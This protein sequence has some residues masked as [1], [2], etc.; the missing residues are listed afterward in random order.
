MGDGD[1]TGSISKQGDDMLRHYLYEAAG[2]LLTTVTAPSAR[3]KLGLEASQVAGSQARA[4]GS[5]T[6]IGGF[7]FRALE[8]GGPFPR[9]AERQGFLETEIVKFVRRQS[10][11]CP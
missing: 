9:R 3:R 6:Q 10:P 4:Q 11:Q 5:C 8:E 2:C 7:A 1:V